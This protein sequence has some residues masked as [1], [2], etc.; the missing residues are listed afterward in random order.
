MIVANDI[1]RDDIGEEPLVFEFDQGSDSIESH[2]QLTTE[3]DGKIKVVAVF[4]KTTVMNSVE[5][6]GS[7]DLKVTG[8]LK[9][10]YNF[11]GEGAITITRFAG[12]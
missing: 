11:Y 8:T 6:Y 12:N 7:F 10:G 3:S 1:G 9:S 5:G 2:D 4:D